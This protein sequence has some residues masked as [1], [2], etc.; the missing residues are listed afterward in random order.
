MHHQASEL[1]LARPWFL[2]PNAR[3]TDP[4]IPECRRLPR[5]DSRWTFR[6]PG[7]TSTGVVPL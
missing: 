3:G 5:S 7:D 1:A 4:A 6:F 2:G